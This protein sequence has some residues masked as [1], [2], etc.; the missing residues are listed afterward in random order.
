MGH[1]SMNIGKSGCVS[2]MAAGDG[3]NLLGCRRG[4]DTGVCLLLLTP[5]ASEESKYPIVR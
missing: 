2:E 4:Y 3:G 1:M 5:C